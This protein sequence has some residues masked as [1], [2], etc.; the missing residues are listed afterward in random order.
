MTI[1]TV[2]SSHGSAGD[3]GPAPGSGPEAD[4]GAIRW[5]ALGDDR[6]EPDREPLLS[7]LCRDGPTH[8]GGNLGGILR[9]ISAFGTTIPLLVVEAGRELSDV[10]S[11]IARYV[12]YPLE[13]ARRRTSAWQWR[14]LAAAAGGMAAGLECLGLGRVVYVNNWLLSTNPPLRLT[15]SQI[16]A[17]TRWLA[18]E[19]PEHAIVYR[20]VNPLLE[21]GMTAS[22]LDAGC[23]L[24]AT[25][26]VYV[27]DTRCPSFHRHSDVRK[28]RQLL[29]TT[30][31]QL[32]EDKTSISAA[33]LHRLEDL[34]RQL[35]IGKHCRHNAQFN[36][37]FFA[38]LLATPMIRAALFRDPESGRLDAFSLYMETGAYLTGCQIGYDLTLPRRLGLYRM[39]MMHK[40]LLAERRGLLVNLSGGAGGFKCLRGAEPVREYD[41]VFD[42]HLPRHRRLPWR[43]VSLEGRLFGRTGP[44][45]TA[46][47]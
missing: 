13:E 15:G 11:P 42:R 38:R 32:C 6:I 19:F 24:I 34:Y 5:L 25:R 43:L 21:P 46:A 39:A 23:R 36:A 27:I 33:D 31:H 7:A 26:V 47:P 1:H 44:H 41:A 20:T 30:R 17:L 3:P 4:P 9:L 14:L 22:L 40:V 12:D 10:C 28:D 8:F 37:A 45:R 2:P 18:R 16:M 29:Q 35:Y